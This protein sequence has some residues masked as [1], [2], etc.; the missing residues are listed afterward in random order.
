MLSALMMTPPRRSARAEASRDLPLA[1][2]P[3][4]TRARPARGCTIGQLGRSPRCKSAG[5]RPRF[6]LPPGRAG[7][8]S[9]ELFRGPMPEMTTHALLLTA[10]PTLPGLDETVIGAVRPLLAPARL[11]DQHWLAEGVAWQ[12]LLA[13]SAADEATPLRAR[14]AAALASRPID[15]NVVPAAVASRRKNL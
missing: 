13:P 6:A 14:L 12:G 5:R 11:I 4:L 1:G 3:A 9:D 8:A 10:S 15:V 2:G 7:C